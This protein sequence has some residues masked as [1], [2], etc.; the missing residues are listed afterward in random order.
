MSG[1]RYDAIVVGA[2]CAG[3][4]SAMLLARKGYRVLAVDR[5]TF[6]SDTISTHLIHPHGVASLKTWGLLERI[7]ATGC[8]PIHTYAFDVGPFVLAGSPAIEGSPVSYGPRRSVLDKVLVDAAAEAG[9][10]IR[11][12]FVVDDLVFDNGGVAGIRG[13]GKG[14]GAVEERAQVVIGADGLHS[15][16]ARAAGAEPYHEKPALEVSYYAYWSGLPMEGRFEAYDRGTRAFAAWPTNDG[17]TV[18]IAGWPYAEFGTN[19]D[20]IES[21]FLETIDLVPSFAARLRAAHREERFVGMAVPNY[22]RK[23]FGPGWVL[24]GDAGYNK[25]F[26]TAQGISDAFRDA[27]LCTGAIDEAFSGRRPYDEAMA[28]YQA[29]RDAAA[30]PVYEFTAGFARLQPAPPEMQQLLGAIH[31][32][33]EATDGFVRVF[34]GVTSPAAFFAPD[35]VTRI[36]AAAAARANS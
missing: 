7:T 15:L 35:N 1:Y 18:A 34:A 14:A 24:V 11:E 19:R 12:G 23:P 17:L 8:P 29:T 4:P 27:E 9:A 5:A 25:D 10:E 31:G 26:I 32:N 30:L 2:R 13:H 20:A 6:P 28:A 33:Q 22:F 3:A 16:V 36:V 21:R